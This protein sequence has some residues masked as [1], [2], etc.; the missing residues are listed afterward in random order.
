MDQVY[1]IRHKVLV[2][3]TAGPPGR[4]RARASHATR[5]AVTLDTSVAIGRRAAVVRARP[6]HARVHERLDALL[7]R[8]AAV[9]RRQA[10]AD[11]DAAARMLGEEGFDGRRDDCVKEAFASGNGSARE[12]FVPLVYPAGRSGR[13][14]LLRGARR[15]RRQRRKAWMFVMRLMHSGRDFAWLYARQDQIAFLDGHVR[16]FAHFGVRAAANRVRQPARRR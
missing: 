9:D 2:E 4:E 16:A 13:G 1:V 15:P 11:G 6:V 12:V 7:S 8:V 5:S 3:G 14:R 10:A